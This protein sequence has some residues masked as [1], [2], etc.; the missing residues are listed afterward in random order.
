[1]NIIYIHTHDTGTYIQP[2][3]HQVP[4]PNL[5]KLAKEGLVFRQM[6]S[7]APT[8][9]A[10]R[11]AMM[12][13][14]SPHSCGMNG[15]AHRGFRLHDYEQHMASWFRKAGVDT[16]LCG[17][18]HE[19]PDRE[20]I[21]YSQILNAPY[22]LDQSVESLAE[23][24]RHHASLAADFIQQSHERPFFLSLGLY[25]T[26]REFPQVS[27]AS[28]HYVTPP[29]PLY[30]SPQNRTDMAAYIESAKGMDD[31]VGIVL[32]ALESA[33]CRADTL[34]VFSTDHGLAF[35]RMKCNLLDTGIKVAFMVRFPDGHR[36]GEVSDAL[37]SQIDV[38]PTFCQW[39]GVDSPPWLQGSSMMP[40]MNGEVDVIRDHCFAEV[41]Y[42]AAY[43]PMRMIRS[44]RYKLIRRYDHLAHR[45]A[46]NI[47]DSVSKDF[48]VEHGYLKGTEPSDMLF[49]LYMDPV[50]RVNVREQEDY[51][52]VYEDLSQRLDRWMEE[53]ADPLQYHPVVPLPKQAVVNRQDAI[54]PNERL[55]DVWPEESAYSDK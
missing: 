6:Y 12:T 32:R 24:D 21:G 27:P 45:I 20:M 29:F 15:L 3:G 42:H 26:H 41:S 51:R 14:M 40:L 19:A 9:S 48:L 43:E 44:K 31:C 39:L 10:S 28:A 54:S 17:I 25:Q 11:S 53:T 1:M 4:T 2:Y 37:V 34:V 36:Q 47:D 38:F 35:P 7:A 16:V 33:A 49:D 52:E 50:E 46:A 5:M 55:T 22:K 18:Q 30:D 8:C 23:M 13:G